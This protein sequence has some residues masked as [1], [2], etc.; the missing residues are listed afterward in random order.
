M[1]E[2]FSIY[3]QSN[4][5]IHYLKKIQSKPTRIMNELARSHFAQNNLIS[6]RNCDSDIADLT[7]C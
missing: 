7:A 4:H 2:K 3:K 5:F 1:H 6:K